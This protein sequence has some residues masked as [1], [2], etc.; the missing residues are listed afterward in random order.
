M[1][2]Q[3]PRGRDLI[4]ESLNSEG[5]NPGATWPNP[6]RWASTHPGPF[7]GQ[8]AGLGI[9]FYLTTKVHWLFGIF[10]LGFIAWTLLYWYNI[11]LL[12]KVGDVNPGKVIQLNP[13][14]FAVATNLTKGFGNYPI[15]KI[16]E[17]ELLKE[18]KQLGKIIPTISGYSNNPYGYPFWSEFSPSPMNHGL[19]LKDKVQSYTK[20]YDQSDIDIIDERL[21]KIHKINIP[22][23]YKVDIEASDWKDYPRAQI[24]KLSRLLGPD[25][26]DK[27]DKEKTT[28]ELK[29]TQ[30]WTYESREIEKNSRAHIVKIDN[31]P[32]GEIVHISLDKIHFKKDINTPAEIGHIPMAIDAFRRSIIRL[33]NVK[34][35]SDIHTEGYNKWKEAYDAGHGGIFTITIAEVIETLDS[36]ESPTAN[37]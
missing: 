35:V 24:G 16:V 29:P 19:V 5:S 9:S 22:E 14:R 8:I 28:L 11:R 2:H 4:R 33:K 7:F 25:Q 15:I 36:V 13:D 26:L 18:D 20:C 27:I 17:T 37:P 1:D 30:V 34:K 21:H 32:Q 3:K 23:T 12:F 10:L 31:T 6:L